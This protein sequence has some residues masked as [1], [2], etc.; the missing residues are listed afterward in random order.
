M[1]IADHLCTLNNIGYSD[2]KKLNFCVY[3]QCCQ[4]LKIDPIA[5]EIVIEDTLEE[6]QKIKKSRRD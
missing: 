1:Y 3:E 4:R 6:L 2:V 5:L